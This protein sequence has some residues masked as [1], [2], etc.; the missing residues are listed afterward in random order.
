MLGILIGGL[1]TFM[2]GGL[3]LIVFLGARRIEDEFAERKKE[4]GE[5]RAQAARIPRFLVVN[6]VTTSRVGRPDETLVW[7]VQQYLEMEQVLA[8]EFVLH[9]SLESLYRESG[10]RI[11]GH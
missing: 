4:I 11:T 7:Q 1:F 2:F 9:P 10:R 8:D 3:V 6:P 5:I